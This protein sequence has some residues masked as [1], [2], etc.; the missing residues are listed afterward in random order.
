MK[1]PLSRLFDP[2]SI[3][4]V[5]ASAAP[6]KPGY[7][8]VKAFEKFPGRIYP[9]NP[10][11]GAVL[12]SEIYKSLSDIPEPVDLIAMVVPPQAS[13]DVL[14]EAAAC[15]A[16]A[17]FMVSGGFSETGGDGHK[18]QAEI[19]K[20][21]HDGGIRLLGP[22]TSGFMRPSKKLF[23]TFLPAAA[24]LKPGKIGIV[25]QSGGIN[26][27]M[28]FMANELRL[29]ISLSV[30]IGNGADVSVADAIDY[31]A[32][33]P[34]T[35]VIAVHLEGV[36][37]G[38]VL[39]DTIRR[40]VPR[41][42][43]V[44]LPVG[45]A[46]LGG[47][48]ESHTGNLMG[49]YALTCAGLRQAGAVVV[50][51]TT[52]L[53]DAAHALSN[54]RLAPAAAPGVG[55]LTGQAGPGLLMTDKLRSAGIDVPEIGAETIS[56][57][58]GLLPP[59]TYLKNP[60][61][62]GR[63]LASFGEVCSTLAR[64]PVVDTL[65]IYALHESDSVD[66][67]AAIGTAADLSGKPCV[68]GTQGMNKDIGPLMKALEKRGVTAIASPDRAALAT[69]A[70]VEDSRAQHRLTALSTDNSLQNTS[71]PPL[72]RVLDEASAKDFIGEW[73]IATPQRI[74]CTTH[75]EAQT[76][77]RKISGSVVVKI[78]D[79]RITHKTET[80]GVHLGIRAAKQL[81][82]ALAQIDSIKSRTRK[83][84]YL[85]EAMAPPGLEV[86]IGA[87]NDPSWGPV[88]LLGLGGTAAEVLEDVSM[89]LAPVDKPAALAMI[90][91]LK[92][93]A[94][95]NGFR[96]A[97]KVDKQALAD[98]IVAVG[99][100]VLETPGIREIDLNPVRVYGD[101]DGVLAL[102]ALIVG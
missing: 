29:G 92:S 13:A 7:Q 79:P 60:V 99:H 101:G 102:D 73:G 80:G 27:T 4:I 17:A 89:R 70:L 88:V 72:P 57:I 19:L 59:L 98:V 67:A 22:N 50:D 24:G 64:D 37:D 91:E 44:V 100:I 3:A 12:G 56:K 21:C 14:R 94:L 74:V 75:A 26:I 23:C 16:G 77:K 1:A 86:I 30:G 69:Q 62:T 46:D 25:A 84:R 6:E 18:R 66:F 5:G 34:A 11:G 93:A 87:R 15:S 32:D 52:A 10:R 48:A 95:F 43:V 90:D 63:P 40:T 36:S 8:M 38:R 53:I 54:A 76:A 68:Y 83:K 81:D 41:K 55:I 65:L 85:I 49:T 31:L 28:A 96:G 97:P 33:D 58:A 71:M 42:P 61:D 2:K 20:I 82:A 78:L 51:T 9:V 47:F 39:F 45:K 35:E